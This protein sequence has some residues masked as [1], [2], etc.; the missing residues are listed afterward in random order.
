MENVRAQRKLWHSNA[1][2]SVTYL[3]DDSILSPRPGYHEGDPFLIVSV[4]KQ[5]MKDH[6]DIANP[7]LIN[8]LGEY[9]SFC[10]ADPQE[11][12]RKV[13]SSHDR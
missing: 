9:I 1:T 4:D 12:P 10:R 5:I 3:F 6:G 8:F 2:N 11:P 7:V 13:T